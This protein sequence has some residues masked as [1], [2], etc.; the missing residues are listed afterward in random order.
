MILKKKRIAMLLLLL[1]VVAPM[2][3][4]CVK[5][6]EVRTESAYNAKPALEYKSLYVGWLD[7]R[8]DDYA[9]YRYETKDL[10]KRAI[11]YLNVDSL[12]GFMKEYLPDKTLYF[13][14]QNDRSF[15]KKG[16]LYITFDVQQFE[17]GY[18]MMGGFDYLYVNVSFIDIKTKQ[19]LYNGSIKTSSNGIGPQGYHLEGRMGFAVR[20]LCLFICDKL[21]SR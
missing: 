11:Y 6:Y 5:L 14:E 4:S 18:N 10:W 19:T 3:I 2:F 9:K 12:H 20:N 17:E 1:T 21:N 15:P 16:D 7:L 8:E 13:A